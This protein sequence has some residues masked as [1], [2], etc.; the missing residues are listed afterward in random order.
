MVLK[1]IHQWRRNLLS[2]TNGRKPQKPKRRPD[3]KVEML[4]D[5]VVPANVIEGTN[6]PD[7]L[8]S[9]VQVDT[10]I[11]KRADDRYVFN[12]NWGNG[13][14]VDEKPGEGTDSLD[15]RNIRV[16]LTFVIKANNTV[17][18]SD[19]T[20]KVT[21]QNVE[22]LYGGS[23]GDTFVV[24]RGVTH[25][26]TIFGGGG[27]D[28]LSYQGN[29]SGDPSLRADKFSGRVVVDLATGN[30]T[31]INGFRAN[32]INSIE[33]VEG[34]LN[35][36]KL[37]APINPNDLGVELR[38]DRDKDELI[39]G[40]G[41]D[42]LEGNTDKDTLQGGKGNDQLRGG[43]GNDVYVFTDSFGKDTITETADAGSNDIIDFTGAVGD[44]TVSVKAGT[45]A[46]DVVRTANDQLIGVTN[47]ETVKTGNGNH[48]IKISAL[49]NVP[50]L[51][52]D[53]SAV[54]ADKKVTLDFDKLNRNFSISHR[55]EVHLYSGGL[56]VLEYFDS[57]SPKNRTHRIE[58]TNVYE[59]K[60]GEDSFNY[61]V[62][63]EDALRGT[64]SAA[65]ING[66]KGAPKTGASTVNYDFYK[67]PRNSLK[68]IILDLERKALSGINTSNQTAAQSRIVKLTLPGNQV[69]TFTLHIG[70]AQPKL[71][72]GQPKTVFSGLRT[73]PIEY[74]PNDLNA[75]TSNI[76]AAL[77]KLPFGQRITVSRAAQEWRI[78]F[79]QPIGAGFDV[80]K[81]DESNLAG[82][83]ASLRS[84]VDV[85]AGTTG[86][87]SNSFENLFFISNTSGRTKLPITVI[88][89][90][91]RPPN[92]TLLEGNRNFLDGGNGPDTLF[93]GAFA[94]LRGRA[95]SDLL[96]SNSQT[97]N[98]LDGGSGDDTLIGG[99]GE[100]QLSGGQGRDSLVGNDGPDSLNG[101]NDDDS[102]FGGKDI[103]TLE[104]GEGK[105]ILDGGPDRDTLR[106]GK[107][108]DVYIFENGWGK[109]TV[110]EKEKE[111]TDTLDFSK[112]TEPM[113]FVLSENNLV[114]G[115]GP[116]VSK[117][118]TLKAYVFSEGK[119]L[120]ETANLT[121]SVKLT[122]DS[123]DEAKNSLRHL[124]KIVPSTAD[125]E[126]IFGNYW[127]T[128]E[129]PNVLYLIPPL[130]YRHVYNN[131]LQTMVIDTKAM[132]DSGKKLTLD[133]RAVTRELD[134]KFKVNPDGGTSLEIQKV[135][136]TPL[137][138]L[139]YNPIVIT[140]VDHNT[141]IHGGRGNGNTF[142]LGKGASFAGTIYGG[143]GAKPKGQFLFQ[144]ASGL[145][146]QTV[147]SAY[148]VNTIKLTERAGNIKEIVKDAG[149]VLASLANLKNRDSVTLGNLITYS[150][151]Q[152]GKL[153]PSVSQFGFDVTKL[154]DMDNI[155][156]GPG[157]SVAV[158][159]GIGINARAKTSLVF[160]DNTIPAPRP[161][162]SGFVTV[163]FPI[164]KLDSNKR[165]FELKGALDEVFFALPVLGSPVVEVIFGTG[166]NAFKTKTTDAETEFRTVRGQQ[167]PFTKVEVE[168]WDSRINSAATV[169]IRIDVTK[170]VVENGVFT[171]LEL[172]GPRNA[173]FLEGEPLKLTIT[174]GSD[175]TEY[176]P[177]LRTT[178][179]DYGFQTGINTFT[180]GTTPINTLKGQTS[181]GIQVLAGR[182]GADTYRFRGLPWG[183]TLVL[184]KPDVSFKVDPNTN[185]KIPESFDTL[186]F[187]G[188]LFTDM[189]FDIFE[190]TTGNLGD[191][192]KILSAFKSDSSAVIDFPLQIGM[193]IVLASQDVTGLGQSFTDEIPDGIGS[194]VIALDIENIIG[195]GLRNKVVFHGNASLSGT[196]QAP[197][198]TF[199]Y[200]NY[201]GPVKGDLSAHTLEIIKPF[202]VGS[203]NFQ[204]LSYE[205]GGISG[206]SGY[207]FGGLEAL[208]D[209]IPGTGDING[210]VES[211]AISSPLASKFVDSKNN[212]TVRGSSFDDSFDIGN[213]GLDVID[214]AGSF[215]FGDTI[216]AA[217]ASQNVYA[218]LQDQGIWQNT[219][220]GTGQATLTPKT[221]SAKVHFELVITADDGAFQLTAGGKT[222]EYLAH[223]ISPKNLQDKLQALTGDTKIQVT[224]LSPSGFKI[225]GENLAVDFLTLGAVELFNFP[226]TFQQADQLA[227]FTNI[228]NIAGGKGNDVLRG[229]AAGEIYFLDIN[230]GSDT[231]FVGGA[232]PSDKDL[233]ELT[234]L[235]EKQKVPTFER[236]GAKTVV[237]VDNQIV[238][239]IYGDRALIDI[240]PKKGGRV[241]FNDQFL[242]LSSGAQAGLVNQ[243]GN[244]K[245]S[246]YGTNNPTPLSDQ[247]VLDAAFAE[248]KRRWSLV[249]SKQAMATV[250]Q[251]QVQW[252]N[253]SS[254]A[255][256]TLGLPDKDNLRITID[257]TAAGHG[258][259]I[260]ATPMLDE[261]FT[262]A[263][264]IAKLAEAGAASGAID[265]ITVLHHEIGHV[266]GFQDK[267]AD[268]S[269]GV[270]TDIIGPGVRVS[271]IDD[272]D[273]AG[274]QEMLRAGLQN[275]SDWVAGIGG[276]VVSELDSST[277]IPLTNLTLK[278]VFGVG[279]NFSADVTAG[280]QQK[281]VNQVVSKF[282]SNMTT[283]DLVALP[284]IDL[285]SSL[286]GKEFSAVVD[287]GK[288]S[289]PVNLDLTSLA[290]QASAEFGFGVDI[291]DFGLSVTG[292]PVELLITPILQLE[293]NFGIDDNGEFFVNNP[294]IIASVN[295][296]HTN[297]INV[298]IAM[299]PLGLSIVDG[300][301]D[302]QAGFK[303]GVDQQFNTAQMID[304]NSL[305]FSTLT[306]DFDENSFF[307]I[308]LPLAIGAGA[309]GFT[310]D[311]P[312]ITASSEQVDVNRVTNMNLINFIGL[313]PSTM[314][315]E[316]LDQLF[317]FS[318]LTLAD[319]TSIIKSGIDKL[320]D[321]SKAS[322]FYEKQPII[323]QSINEFLGT[324]TQGLIQELKS[325]LDQAE[326]A[327]KDMQSLTANF[328]AGLKSFL[329]TLTGTTITDDIFKIEYNDGILGINLDFAGAFKGQVDVNL[330][331]DQFVDFGTYGVPEFV[332]KS[333]TLTSQS[334]LDVDAS[335][336]IDLQ[337]D[338][339]LAF[340]SE[341]TIGELSSNL[342]SLDEYVSFSPET[343]L[344]FALDLETLT[345]LDLQ[346]TV[347]VS[348][349]LQVGFLVDD[350]YLN[351][352]L[353]G[354]FAADGASD[355]IP[356]SL[357][358]SQL[359][360]SIDGTV[361][362]NLPV[363]FPTPNLPLGGD[364]ADNNADGI[365]DHAFFVDGEFTDGTFEGT[366]VS[367]NFANMFQL[368]QV[369]N[370]PQVVL[371]G[372]ESFFDE[373]K[374]LIK[375]DFD[376]LKLPI[377]DDKLK[378]AE[379]FIDDL[380][381]KLLGTKVGSTYQDGLG[382]D[383][384]NAVGSGKT[385]IQLIQE[386]L[387]NQQEFRSLLKKPQRDPITKELQFDPQTGV[388]LFE[389]IT[390]PKDIQLVLTD[391]GIEFDLLL[392]GNI[393][394]KSI[395]LSFDV[396][397]PGLG[398]N[399]TPGSNIQLSLDYTLGLGLGF[400]ITDGLY[401]NTE[402]ITEAGDELSI[403][404][405][406]T[407][408]NGAELNGT[409]GFLSVKMT[410][411]ADSDG[412]SG[413]FGRFNVDLVSS[414]G[415][416]WRIGRGDKLSINTT[417]TAY[418]NVD[419]ALEVAMSNAALGASQSIELP[420]ITTIFR[421]DQI[422]AQAGT[423]VPASF[424]NAPIV[425][426]AEVK[427]DLGEFIN[428]F[429]GPVMDVVTRVTKPLQPLADIL[430]KPIPVLQSLGAENAS[431]IDIVKGVLGPTQFYSTVLAIE[432]IAE[433][434]NFLNKVQRF[435]EANPGEF[436]IDFGT[437]TL[438]GDPRTGGRVTATGTKLDQGF[439]PSNQINNGTSGASQAREVLKSSDKGGFEFP[440]LKKPS[441]ILGLL[442]G[443]KD[444][445]LFKWNM[446]KIDLDFE[447]V[448]SIPVFPGL[449]ARFGGRIK[450]KTN[451]TFAFD[452]SG[453]N[454]WRK[455]WDTTAA[456]PLDYINVSQ[457]GKVFQG[458]FL[459]D[460]FVN[461]VDTPEAV[462][463]ASIIAG[464]SVGIRGFVEA[465]VDGD[466]TADIEFDLNDVD[467]QGSPDGD[468]K[469]FFSELDQQIQKFGPLGIL[470][471]KGKFS[472]GLTAF[473]WV[474]ADIG[475]ARVKLFD[476]R[477]QLARVTLAN[478]QKTFSD[479][480]S[481]LVAVADVGPGEVVRFTDN[482]GTS[483]YYDKANDGVIHLN[484]GANAGARGDG[485]TDPNE[486]FVI[487]SF[488][489][490][491]GSEVTRIT[492]RGFVQEFTGV[493]KIIAHGGS[494]ND[495]IIVERGVTADVVLVGG[496]GDDFL[497][498]AGSGKAQIDG[499]AGNDQIVVGK[500]GATIL[501]GSG[502]D[503]IL[504][505]DGADLI[506]GG[507]GNDFI[508]GGGGDDT[509][510]GGVGN[511]VV[512]GRAGNDRVYGWADPSIDVATHFA[513]ADVSSKTV[514]A[515]AGG[516]ASTDGSDDLDGDGGS[517]S[518]GQEGVDYVTIDGV[519]FAL[520]TDTVIGGAGDDEITAGFGADS[521]DGG[522]GKDM[523][524]VELV[525]GK[526]AGLTIVGGTDGDVLYL[527]GGPN[528]DK[529]S[530]ANQGGKLEV[531]IGSGTFTVDGVENVAIRPGAGSDIIT[532]GN[533]SA[534]DVT[535]MLIDLNGADE[536][537]QSDLADVI[538]YSGDPTNGNRITVRD[539]TITNQLDAVYPN[540]TPGMWPSMI[541]LVDSTGAGSTSLF[542][543]NSDINLDKLEITGGNA[544]DTISVVA[545]DGTDR[546][547]DLIRIDV[548]GGQGD[549]SISA[550]YGNVDLKGGA[551]TDELI[552]NADPNATGRP[553]IE[554]GSKGLT[555]TRPSTPTQ[556]GTYQGFETMTVN[557]GD[558]ATGSLLTVRDPSVGSLT[559]N[560]STGHDS[561]T[562]AATG[563]PISVNLNQ[564]ND[565]V[566]VGDGR[567]N[568]FKAALN[569]MGGVGNDTVL[570]DNRNDS[571]N[572][573]NI[574]IGAT[575]VTGLDSPTNPTFDT[576]IEAV[577]LL[578][579]FGD[580]TVNITDQNRLVEVIGNNT[581]TDKVN[582]TVTG[583][584]AA[585][586][587]RKVTTRSVDTVNF[588]YND[589][590]AANYWLLQGSELIGSSKAG[591]ANL[592]NVLLDA[593][594]ATATTAT[595]GTGPDDLIVR[596]LTEQFTVNLRSGDDTVRLG[597]AGLSPAPGS[598]ID[599]VTAALSLIGGGQA[600]DA[601]VF[602]ESA[603]T[604]TGSITIGN[605]VVSADTGADIAHSGF[606][607]LTF[608]R[609]VSSAKYQIRVD[610]TSTTT[611]V[612][613]TGAGDDTVTVVGNTSPL[614]VHGDPRDL[615][616]LDSRMSKAAVNATLSNAQ[617]P[618]PTAYRYRDESTDVTF[619]G[620][621]IVEIA[622]SEQ[623]DSL[624]IDTTSKSEVRVDGRGGDDTVTIA[625]IGGV[626]DILGGGGKDVALVN[627]PGMPSSGVSARY[628][629][630]LR[631]NAE[632]LTVDNRTNTQPVDWKS[633][634]G[635]LQFNDAGTTG[636]QDLLRATGAKELT[637]IGGTKL[638]IV[639]P[640]QDAVTAEIDADSVKITQN[641]QIS[642]AVPTTWGSTADLNIRQ[643]AASSSYLFALD[644]SGVLY[645]FDRSSGALVD[646][647]VV[648]GATTSSHMDAS[649]SFANEGI[650]VTTD[651]GVVHY[652][653]NRLNGTLTLEQT[654]NVGYKPV[655]VEVNTSGAS[656]LW[657]L[658]ETQVRIYSRTVNTQD[659]SVAFDTPY[660]LAN[661]EKV[662][663][664]YQS[665]VPEGRNWMFLVVENNSGQSAIRVLFFDNFNPPRM[666]SDDKV[667]AQGDD[668]IFDGGP[669]AFANVF[670]YIYAASPDGELKVFAFTG[671]EPVLRNTIYEGQNQIRGLAGVSAMD[672]STDGRFLFVGSGQAGTLTVL[673]RDGNGD[674]LIFR[675]QLHDNFQTS[676]G[677]IRAITAGGDFLAAERGIQRVQRA[678]STTEQSFQV[679]F[680]NIGAVSVTTGDLADVFAQTAAPATQAFT[681]NTQGGSD[682][683]SLTDNTSTLTIN[684]GLGDET[685]VLDGQF[686]GSTMINTDR[687]NESITFQGTVTGSLNIN[688]GISND[689][690]SVTADV[691]KN[692]QLTINGNSGSNLIEVGGNFED[693]ST[694]TLS[695]GA[696]FSI[697]KLAEFTG[698]KAKVAINA[699]TRG[700]DTITASATTS[701]ATLS[702]NGSPLRDTVNLNSV[703]AGV[704][705]ILN[706]GDGDDTANIAM[707]KVATGGTVEVNGG[708]G[709]DELN[710]GFPS[711]VS[712]FPNDNQNPIWYVNDPNDPMVEND[713]YVTVSND[714]RLQYSGI[715]RIPGLTP[716]RAFTG[717]PYD[718]SF[719][720]GN[721]F[722][723]FREGRSLQLNGDYI[724]GD[725]VPG[726]K[727]VSVAWDLD[728]DGLF[729]DFNSKSGRLTWEEL[730]NVTKNGAVPIDDD[731]VYTISIQV[732]DDQGTVAT[733]STTLTVVDFQP[734]TTLSLVGAPIFDEEITRAEVLVDQMFQIWVTDQGNDPVT[735]VRIDWGD[736]TPVQVID[737]SAFETPTDFEFYS[738]DRIRQ[739]ALVSHRYMSIGEVN[740]KITVVNDSVEY[741]LET[742]LRV[743]PT[744]PRSDVYDFNVPEGGSITFTPFAP[745]AKTFYLD[746]DGDYASGGPAEMTISAGQT[747]SLP[748]T[749]GNGSADDLSDFG[750]TDSGTYTIDLYSDQ[751]VPGGDDSDDDDDGGSQPGKPRPR[752]TVTV[753][754]VAPTATFTGTTVSQGDTA[755]VRFTGISDP[756][757][758]DR[759]GVFNFRL[760]LDAEPP[761]VLTGTQTGTADFSMQVLAS[762]LAKM[763]SPKVKA[764]IT[765]KDGGETMYEGS[766]ELIKVDPTLT[767]TG[768]STATEGTAYGLSL[769]SS[770]PSL[771]QEWEIIWGDGNTSKSNESTPTIPHTFVDDGVY[772]VQVI[773][774][775]LFGE[776]FAAPKT[777]TVSNTAPTLT[778]TA[779]DT[780]LE[781]QSIQL[782]LGYQDPGQDSLRSWTINWGDGS[783]VET[784]FGRQTAPAATSLFTISTPSAALITALN[785][786]TAVPA[787]VVTAFNNAGLTLTAD[788]QVY[789]GV[790][791]TQWRIIDGQVEYALVLD[792]GD[793]K[794]SDVVPVYPTHTYADD[795][796][797]T[798]TVTAS[799][800]DG[801]YQA[802]QAITVNNVAPTVTT[803]PVGSL[804]EGQEFTLT[805]N[806]P[807][808]PGTDNVT[809]IL[810]DWGDGSG[811]DTLTV[812]TYQQFD[813]DDGTS[814]MV[815]VPAESL[816]LKHTYAD[817]SAGYPVTIRLVDEDGTHNATALTLPV[818]NVAPVLTFSG[819]GVIDQGQVYSLNLTGI[820]DPG[821]DNWQSVRIVWG[822]N[823]LDTVVTKLGT[824]PHTYRTNGIETIE[825]YVTDEEGEHFQGNQF[826]TVNDV[827]AT[828]QISTSTATL[829]E[830]DALTVNFNGFSDPGGE[831]SPFATGYTVTWGDGVTTNESGS[832][833]THTYTDDVVANITVIP[834]VTNGFA[835]PGTATVT[836]TNVAPSFELGGDATISS[837]L[838][839]RL[840]RT[841]VAITDPGADTWTSTVD[842]G[843][844]SG[845]KTLTIDQMAK[846]FD[847]DHNYTTEG[848]FTVS[849]TV[850]DDN[851]G[852]HTDTF[853]VTTSLNTAPVAQN[854]A[855]ATDQNTSVLVNV[856]TGAGA[857]TDAENNIVPAKTVALTAPAK[858]TLVNNLDGTFWFDPNG[859]F[860]SLRVGASEQVSFD[861]Q[862]QDG[863]GQTSTGTVTITV[864]GLNET[865]EVQVVFGET[866]E[867]AGT[868]SIDF[869]AAAS[870]TDVDV[871]DVL[872][873]R[874]FTL[875]SEGNYIYQVSGSMLSFDTAQFAAMGFGQSETLVFEY[876]LADDSGAENAST[877]GSVVITV[878]GM[879]AEPSLLPVNSATTEDSGT[880]TIDLI[881]A[882]GV[883]AEDPATVFTLRSVT[884]RPGASFNFTPTAN[885]LQFDTA[886]FNSLAAFKSEML[887]FDFTI[888]YS[889][890]Q[891]SG[892]VSSTATIEVSG[893]N[894]NPTVGVANN[895]VTFDLGAAASNSGTFGD[896]DM[897][898][899]VVISAADAQGNPVGQITQDAG[900]AG[901]WTWTLAASDL[902]GTITVT[903]VDSNGGQSSTSFELIRQQ[904]QSNVAP[905]AKLVVQSVADRNNDADVTFA[906][907]DV[908][909][910]NESDSHRYSF[911]LSE[912]ELASD[913]AQAAVSNQATFT[914]AANTTATVYAR[915]LDNAS[916]SSTYQF[917]VI[918][919]SKTRDTLVGTAGQDLL[920]GLGQRDVLQGQG[921]D[922][923]LYGGAGHD[924]LFGGGGFDTLNGGA[925]RDLTSGGNQSDVY[926]VAGSDAELDDIEDSGTGSNDRVVNTGGTDVTIN[927]FDSAWSGIDAWDN[928]G[929]QINGNG[930]ANYLD[931]SQ[932]NLTNVTA[933]NG[934]GGHDE[935]IGSPGADLIRGNNGE[936]ILIGLGGD[937]TL[938]GGQGNDQLEGGDGFDVLNG[939][940]E[941]DTLSG[942]DK[943]DVYEVSG[944]EAEHDD[945]DD[946]G[947][948]SND[949][950]VNVGDSDVIIADFD[951][952]QNG[953]D[954]WDNQGFQITGNN[955]GNFLDFSQVNF[956]GVSAIDGLGGNDEIIGSPGADLIRGNKGEDSLHGLGG[957]DTL[958]GG[959]GDD[960][961]EGGDGF[962][963]L[964]G[965][966]EDDTLSGGDK[967]DVY[968]VSGDEA[969]YDDF[970]DEGTGSNDRVV[971]V[972][973]SDVIIAD[974]DST[975]NGIDAWDNQGYQITGNG[976]A[977]YLDFSEVNLTNV[978]AINGD[979]GHDEIIGSPGADLIRGNN[980]EDILIGLGGD[981]TLLG[982]QGN[983]QLEGGD[984]F[985]VLNGG[986]E[987]DTLS[988][989]DKS[990]VYEVSGDE[991]EYDDFDDEGTGSNDRVVNVG[992][993][994]VIIA[995][996]DSTQNGIDAWD[997]QGYQIT[998]NGGANAFDFSQVNLTGVSA[999]DGLGGNDTITGS[1000]GGDTIRGGAGRDQL[1001]GHDGDDLLLG[1002]GGNDLLEGGKGFDTL[1003]GGAGEDTLSGG[1004]HSDTYQV[1005]ADEAEF[1006]TFDDSGTGS[1007]DRIV[1008]VGD[1009]DVVM[1010]DFDSATTGIEVW[1011]NGGYEIQG[1012]GGANFLDFSQISLSNV[1013]A[1014]DARGGNDEVVGSSGND[1015]ILGGGGKDTIIGGNGN[1016]TIEGGAG[1017]DELWGGVGADVFIFTPSQV[1018]EDRIEDF[1019]AEGA[1020]RIDLRSFTT[1021]FS[1022]LVISDDNGD[1023]VIELP[1024]GQSIRLV[1025]FVFGD[1026]DED[1027][1028]L[1029]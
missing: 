687:G 704:T 1023:A 234:G 281:I 772:E 477:I 660:G 439:D 348:N 637:V 145:L 59:V 542:I 202:N 979:G 606:N 533:L 347:D 932:V 441:S 590:G 188:V 700:N 752:V 635:V 843:D 197:N 241:F 32:S 472:A 112:V 393:F 522:A 396:G 422:F 723:P 1022:E 946:E 291:S 984:G 799:D 28:A 278:D 323:N 448:Q 87:A 689:T 337:L 652:A 559:V 831:S 251:I 837:P 775:G 1027:D 312:R 372:F 8:T 213:G 314:A 44:S 686:A 876:T 214:G 913:F 609:T 893:A 894:D 322:F 563:I 180:V 130:L 15:F 970:D 676:F 744:T 661:G 873:Y 656:E 853:Q 100:S 828:L 123:K 232:T 96:I 405:S 324:D 117:Q 816:T 45:G 726:T 206:I 655:G 566:T 764:Y 888:D 158:G 976:G 875:V 897:S 1017:A 442:T 985:D 299:G 918:V 953:I 436:I 80:L 201:S 454:E 613:V 993:S 256:P 1011:D 200:S 621:A 62:R 1014:I 534:T 208:F 110:T 825:V 406:A 305:D 500:Q 194:Y 327:S 480:K 164:E 218:S 344:A 813:F 815:F 493:T 653:Y 855:A 239:T 138:K 426:L 951:S 104:G 629:T 699:G 720:F 266:L 756:S 142:A 610:D 143:T 169:S 678:Q 11:G 345:P 567:V 644:V 330:D 725:Q 955:G 999:I 382:K 103:D 557:L 786:N 483:F 940:T 1000:V 981:D 258:W 690:I 822:D 134:F 651:T 902:A 205:F 973:D 92:A 909:D 616:V 523:F 349:S 431:L 598:T 83:Q 852:S 568:G 931:F 1029:F 666:V 375:S 974:F 50:R 878:A 235:F 849:V 515:L 175:V 580:D 1018:G 306:V 643:L 691:K 854:D 695:S 270:M 447:Y 135:A 880:F 242:P 494:G 461:G 152:A 89:P 276:Q 735:E 745:G 519:Q 734:V 679:G 160:Q 991:A 38:G 945:F 818:R 36:N 969:E 185:I 797:Y 10:L 895:A 564:G 727:L 836:V 650:Y 445:D 107:G 131:R 741:V 466:I 579:G 710:P 14:I 594:G 789:S 1025:G 27:L 827:P 269:R 285:A 769:S 309:N 997:N 762:D 697:I 740:P 230:S 625:S 249:L 198:L 800:E 43:K 839:G 252:G 144:T 842:Y 474:G 736:G 510:Q 49:P 1009:T 702:I 597:D 48:L 829:A 416:K 414:G 71:A 521:M 311:G 944:D 376:L 364:T 287:L 847:L 246:A 193:N 961:L 833:A 81:I 1019:Q 113:V 712:L 56:V 279:D 569:I 562:V 111:G 527:D 255:D 263:A 470:N 807:T 748:W 141:V 989:G 495:Q 885:G 443:D 132:I 237:K 908:V 962:D 911:A 850:T 332:G 430:V 886:Q 903:A 13:D 705:A 499:G 233:I 900:N 53:N 600:A 882:S 101:G 334:K 587:P 46:I 949:R 215:L 733:S 149:N 464:A 341:V 385:T 55:I 988:G 183:A 473:L 901:T 70:D 978:T 504:G 675:Q 265:L 707:N 543:T 671:A 960:E 181:F 830:G 511:D 307:N 539:K 6:N 856:L 947:T 68:P 631:I 482:T 957:D 64:L 980:G 884:A 776:Y 280:V 806:P 72:D 672:V 826:V 964:N 887:V 465:G 965:G 317:G 5:R 24:S 794:V 513:F 163:D 459:D 611:T 574:V 540:S 516:V 401:V 288:T 395:P 338:V 787:E 272:S 768:G 304:L 12:A 133:F 51:R 927:D 771:I 293:F 446:P 340:L 356:L 223:N 898:N 33:I 518:V 444:V 411:F 122:R 298:G 274:D 591:R 497:S 226:T 694:I 35:D 315:I 392:A 273:I 502:D 346:A 881:A 425:Q 318:K 1005:S 595:L 295:L 899:I 357:F 262:G 310:A 802:T 162:S 125:N 552:L 250:D 524:F 824:V 409:L 548:D 21:A 605:G 583:P 400:S 282:T 457:I 424:G 1024:D 685:I 604:G 941:D 623:N 905:T 891:G 52:I 603:R 195:G 275:F 863:F 184:E 971:N 403:V 261:E 731:G 209:A 22:T 54:P 39:G 7:V 231:I 359:G 952:T 90:F 904:G 924:E 381:V 1021:S 987:D 535:T 178:K 890:A 159:T 485:I 954:A 555:I 177:K 778:L 550:I 823:T 456:N 61:Y 150:S 176:Q 408:P 992:D 498:Y 620:F 728:Q 630:D 531:I 857:D 423:G 77:D 290:A 864:T 636:Y 783:E 85:Q 869:F 896:T 560:G 227:S 467:V 31:A 211:F 284:N 247:A 646:S 313:I 316:D 34:G 190:V 301:I 765:D 663:Q 244:A 838:T 536:V 84:L 654:I 224:N 553:S 763:K 575:A 874:N 320:A 612:D 102:L 998:G 294:Q 67:R 703:A 588:T 23:A 784:I 753:G 1008:N 362:M 754:N 577:R 933:I 906:L 481:Q 558:V 501:G 387:F 525:S 915:V 692:A 78:T 721:N 805:F 129:T 793:L 339:D 458:F 199:D 750:I 622:L 321:P 86:L 877:T 520:G 872:S 936:D 1028:F 668:R 58:I 746:F 427:L 844:G 124:E 528:N 65:K 126:F 817:D 174:R 938:L 959:Q 220:L 986:T 228:A 585:T 148:V 792:S 917:Q 388:L 509:L 919:G 489:A 730:Y 677:D 207:R 766:I 452:T 541:E 173:L 990:D 128:V 157:L 377:I 698:G 66:G 804:A 115:T 641:L 715:D 370:D 589:T 923:V 453:L 451:F 413:L 810:V 335:I 812:G 460:H 491:D 437:F 146:N 791:G 380:R 217:G 155:T 916:A 669:I 384:Q 870:P 556:T 859:E 573:P 928:G 892:S 105:D 153:P 803:Q 547:A 429:A 503:N 186:D 549:D 572:R 724:L 1006:D 658:G 532:L 29:A 434:V 910:E 972:G 966:T 942:G 267:G 73:E 709:T 1012:N 738:Y 488:E 808:D 530:L 257:A 790:T 861:Y 127:G 229:S 187:A 82:G 69:G 693:D 633:E 137:G 845:P 60:G 996:F 950:V 191:W 755:T 182:G 634:L 410:D 624:R 770:H 75:T 640:L 785:T 166:Q 1010:S 537:S 732:T 328:N 391:T 760:E 418:A 860:D 718:K 172:A 17:V 581:G 351:L 719:F 665:P 98:T 450:A 670:E 648:A 1020:D 914:F 253:L 920:L 1001:E 236:N 867:D 615:V 1004:D 688:S 292:D 165:T 614:T 478:F 373:M 586:D 801:S 921:G 576:S 554:L 956:T 538:R 245:A 596:S 546:A 136:F 649:H 617:T 216:R 739:R 26:G 674:G 390:A 203:L 365:A 308:D 544:A 25:N 717:G 358:V 551:G 154:Y 832:S 407:V 840:L 682:S 811:V 835:I 433:S 757:A 371:N 363:F 94:D 814:Q 647:K 937:D 1007:G 680:V 922:D 303:I 378:G 289:F 582:A 469:I 570:I 476:K 415:D 975:Q 517:W 929:Y 99:Q 713:N 360:S 30:A 361:E 967:S 120:V 512:E 758:A 657:I 326:A 435:R 701:G 9:T 820:V 907:I 41:F 618:M 455:T 333:F 565:L 729:D 639:A 192:T 1003:E 286:N 487:S 329:G 95:G 809:Q 366:V 1015:L 673:E 179:V 248:A 296:D 526:E 529:L 926:E 773:A 119:P 475:I 737:G 795:G 930:G 592:T 506:Q 421:Y 151:L 63:A 16:P 866:R 2:R 841:A 352:D 977:N 779:P 780:S 147:R 331:L 777:V 865:P 297:P 514:D 782:R 140:N 225:T 40:A 948:G 722:I 761:I 57:T 943:S 484:M 74:L 18:V 659:W 91:K 47:V 496:E 711:G 254:N 368:A 3:L 114:A 463:S 37:T 300:N 4:E 468:N 283:A 240:G 397:A 1026:L 260:D 571:Q 681:I 889:N 607:H 879:S 243:G 88:S 20:N 1:R 507:A 798:I 759:A 417:L 93:G 325:L 492:Y 221:V 42:I 846:T 619:D 788:A 471:T 696:G 238:A 171:G 419:L 963:V 369:L 108:D 593:K 19:G 934:G 139:K 76:Q 109:D 97:K 858:G 264:G 383:L 834:I 319:L 189:R 684:T 350:A 601:I 402:G 420:K 561:V 628:L 271:P 578:L 958:L 664:A 706:L 412:G 343:N 982:G 168:Q 222:T 354:S 912:A 767:L 116:Y 170:F 626:T 277:K 742:I 404:I 259:F 925:G 994:D 462:L 204:G 584:I 121:N 440:I 749:G 602:D 642:Y 196:I 302:F 490:A 486:T 995:D 871:N 751:S 1013:S 883:V 432:A 968:E 219:T 1016:D 821:A 428:K 268:T 449:N 662:I 79:P 118:D 545:G 342:S 645:S 848:T 379:A 716:T 627:V 683:L 210:L 386:A 156:T 714:G 796:D 167:V 708:D 983:D 212:D 743:Q 868:Y 1002:E 851:G 608:K 374:S 355:R 106:G 336:D 353:T 599:N 638:D 389:S 438:N 819:P 667:Y 862:I 747:V 479:K 505:G 508:V 774:R 939:G 399:T 398:L 632:S 781:G 394:S 161:A 935:I 367:P